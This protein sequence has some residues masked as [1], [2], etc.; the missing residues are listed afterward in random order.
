MDGILP[1][2]NEMFIIC[3]RDLDIAFAQSFIIPGGRSSAP[4]DLLLFKERSC[5][6]T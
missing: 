4:V 1:D 6:S 2:F 5:F 3:A